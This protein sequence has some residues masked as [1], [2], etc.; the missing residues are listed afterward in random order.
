MAKTAEPDFLV[1][2]PESATSLLDDLGQGAYT[3]SVSFYRVVCEQSNDSKYIKSLEE[4]IAH[5]EY[6]VLAMILIIVTI[7]YVYQNEVA[8]LVSFRPSSLLNSP[9]WF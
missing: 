3:P 1:L 8:A 9:S 6:Y 5:T 7:F 4:N 2:N